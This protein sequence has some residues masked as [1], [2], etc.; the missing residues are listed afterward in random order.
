MKS[1]II[2]LFS[3]FVW[4]TVSAQTINWTTMDSS[5][6]IVTAGVGWDY[7]IAYSVGY[8]YQLEAKLPLVLNLQFVK[9]SGNAFLDDFKTKIGGQIVLLD[10]SKIKG[11]VTL[12]GIYRRYEN[13]LV[14]LHNF[15]SEM[16]GTFGYYQPKWFVAAEVDFDKAI[17]THF[18]HS[19][20]YR[21]DVY[22]D[23]VDGWY[24]PATG[25]NFSFGIQ[26]GYSLKK[27]DITFN[28]GR[29]LTQDFK[30]TPLIPYY[31]R[32]GYYYKIN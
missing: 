4:K 27:S 31:L 11:A 5:K 22:S 17:V 18:K 16:R 10:R 13:D 6:H 1:I 26:T 9:P 7:G 28:F 29:V 20:K 32:L 15:G 24:E 12:N 14:R 21:E 25:G 23:V 19:D 3:F 2:T 30:T 8:G